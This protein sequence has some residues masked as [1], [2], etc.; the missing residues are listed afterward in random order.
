[1]TPHVFLSAP[2][3]WPWPCPFGSKFNTHV[4]HIFLRLNVEAFSSNRLDCR[5]K[6]RF[7]KVYKFP[8]SCSPSCHPFWRNS[9]VVIWSEEFFQSAVNFKSY[10][11]PRQFSFTY[12]WI[13]FLDKIRAHDI[14]VDGRLK[15]I[16]LTCFAILNVN[17]TPLN[18][19]G[20]RKTTWNLDVLEFLVLKKL[21]HTYSKWQNMINFRSLRY[22]R[23]RI[24]S[25]LLSGTNPGG[26]NSSFDVGNGLLPPLLP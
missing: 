18:S 16:N 8:F 4:R 20:N 19:R 3:K 17:L 12:K 5:D 26:H 7:H 11:W 22:R 25:W 2:E 1:M 24:C 13:F 15:W 23:Q 6:W 14:M 9:S 21:L 10:T